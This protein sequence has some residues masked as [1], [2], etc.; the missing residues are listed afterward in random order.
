M[1]R[2]SVRPDSPMAMHQLVLVAEDGCALV[3][4]SRHRRINR[5]ADM[6][7][8]GRSGGALAIRSRGHRLR[9]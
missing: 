4:Q 3:R 8:A 7:A 6:P 9:H 5:K 1:E 2:R